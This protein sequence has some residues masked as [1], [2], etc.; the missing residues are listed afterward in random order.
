MRE[1]ERVM[2]ADLLWTVL[3]RIQSLIF[4]HILTKHPREKTPDMLEIQCVTVFCSYCHQNH[5]ALLFNPKPSVPYFCLSQMCAAF[6]CLIQIQFK[7]IDLKSFF[8]F[9]SLGERCCGSSAKQRER[10][11]NSGRERDTAVQGDTPETNRQA[12]REREREAKTVRLCLS[13]RCNKYC[14]Y[15]R[16][17]EVSTNKNIRQKWDEKTF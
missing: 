4:S 11:S 3:L 15:S 2:W 13:M 16:G 12:E 6:P 10:K 9:L 17:V 14:E 1:G 8:F 7:G 5:D